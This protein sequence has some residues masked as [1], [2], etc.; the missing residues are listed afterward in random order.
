MV[1]GGEKTLIMMVR[2]RGHAL[3]IEVTL[4]KDN[5]RIEYFIP[6]ICYV[7]MVNILPGVI[8]V[9]D[10]SIGTTGAIEVEVKDLPTALFNFISMVPT[11]MD[12][13]HNYGRGI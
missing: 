5:A 6:K 10:D 4:N 11:D 9:I 7:E 1:R 3:S 8:I 12:I 13:V 2:D